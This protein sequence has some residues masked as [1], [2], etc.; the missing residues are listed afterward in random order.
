VEAGRVSLAR[1]AAARIAAHL[2][3]VALGAG[4]G[5]AAYAVVKGLLWLTG[6]LAWL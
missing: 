4:F 1:A 3:V 2:R 6:G 5:L